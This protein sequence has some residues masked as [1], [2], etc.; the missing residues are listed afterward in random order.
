MLCYLSFSSSSH[1]VVLT[2][3][4]LQIELHWLCSIWQQSTDLN[5]IKGAKRSRRHTHSQSIGQAQPHQA[6][7]C[8]RCQ[9]GGHSCSKDDPG[10]QIILGEMQVNNYISLLY[11]TKHNGSSS[12][13]VKHLE[14]YCIHILYCM[15]LNKYNC[16]MSIHLVWTIHFLLLWEVLFK[17]QGILYIHRYTVFCFS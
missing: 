15:A 17:E 10:T 9:D 6:W 2:E 13:W 14:T 12:R 1:C 11:N 7:V 16:K 3:L 8:S 5:W 4:I